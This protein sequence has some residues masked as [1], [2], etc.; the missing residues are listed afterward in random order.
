[1]LSSMPASS[2]S[3]PA[4]VS[5]TLL[6]APQASP[7]GSLSPS[8]VDGDS[9]SE[10]SDVDGRPHSDAPSDTWYVCRNFGGW[11]HAFSRT[12]TGRRENVPRIFA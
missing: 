5:L 2:L 7:A 6:M 9:Y 12:A 8:V 4:P 10:D 3:A 1:M 11:Q